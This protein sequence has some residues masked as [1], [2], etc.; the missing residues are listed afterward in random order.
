MPKASNLSIAVGR[1]QSANQSSTTR[2]PLSPKS[3]HSPRSARLHDGELSAG[4]Y[5][6][7]D[8][9]LTPIGVFPPP[10]VSPTSPKHR[11][12]SSRSFFSLPKASKSSTRLNTA[13]SSIRRVPEEMSANAVYPYGHSAGSTRSFGQSIENI[14]VASGKLHCRT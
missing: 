11:K 6:P 12:D 5:T 13:E 9:Q 4:L 3:P 1:E 8:E 2:L 10:P 14:S 7:T